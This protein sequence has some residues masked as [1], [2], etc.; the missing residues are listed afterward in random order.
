MAKRTYVATSK[1]CGLEPPK[2]D[3]AG[4]VLSEHTLEI[5]DEYSMDEAAAAPLVAGGSLVL[6]GAPQV[7]DLD[8][9]EGD[10]G[11]GK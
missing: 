4:N 9:D 2:T 11:R 7:P 3:K 8:E 5:G 10:K 1:I 6:K